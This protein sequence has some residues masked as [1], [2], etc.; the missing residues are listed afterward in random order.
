M[1]NPLRIVFKFID[2]GLIKRPLISFTKIHPLHT[3]NNTNKE[4]V[5]ETHRR[6]PFPAKA[7]G[8]RIQVKSINNKS[9]HIAGS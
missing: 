5:T 2:N 9:R 6:L 4:L 1:E 7:A 8:N 3:L